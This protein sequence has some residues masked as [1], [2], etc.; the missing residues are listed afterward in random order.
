MPERSE[1]SYFG[2]G[3]AA[4]PTDVL[5][6]A[7]ASLVNHQGLGLGLGE[8]SH[9]SPTA[10]QILA[11]TKANLTKLLNIPDDY[12]IL[13][14]QGGGTGQFSAVVQNLVSVWI[15][16]RRRKYAA[17]LGEENETEIIAEVQKEID[18]N[19]KLDYIVTGSWSLKAS[20]EA[21]RMLGSKYVNVAADAKKAN[22][23]KFGVIPSED[24]WN[25][26]PTP[27]EGGKAAPA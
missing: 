9:R 23:G 14:M 2:A 22:D 18:E 19:L 15:E 4:L 5:E 21:Q 3:P 11:D 12:E 17:S 16:R 7:A 26:T 25:L 6:A 13:F 24:T 8:V 20:Q 27:K 1:V 10:N